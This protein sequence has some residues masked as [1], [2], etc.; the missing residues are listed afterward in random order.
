[1]KVGEKIK[2]LRLE[3][4]MTQNQL[5]TISE[6]SESAIRKYE[7]GER[8]PKLEQLTKIANALEVG[9]NDLLSDST[10]NNTW[11]NIKDI[12][13][14]KE[15]LPREI[16]LE[17]KKEILKTMLDFK[18]PDNANA[19]LSAIPKSKIE[20]LLDTILETIDIELMLDNIESEPVLNIKTRPKKNT[21][22][23]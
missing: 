15:M 5:A 19:V 23:D 22:K 7:K 1:M 21:S 6:I 14:V 12:E 17:I 20:N 3:K 9:V 18:N 4:Q 8:Q 13:K 2:A 10:K 16:I 11:I